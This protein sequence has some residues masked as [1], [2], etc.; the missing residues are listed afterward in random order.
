M[1]VHHHSHTARKKWTHYF[2]E[3]LMLF[4]AVT[5][6]F[7]VENKREHY[8][9][10]QRAKELAKNLVKDLKLDTSYMHE[11][12]RTRLEK[13]RDVDSLLAALKNYPSSVNTSKV[14]Q[15]VYSLIFKIHF[16][17]AEGTVNQLKNSG[18]LRYFSKTAV[19]EKLMEYDRIVGNLEEFEITYSNNLDR[20]VYLVF[21]HLDA[22]IA[23]CCWADFLN[24]K[25]IPS[26]APL[27]DMYKANLNYFKNV[28]VS[29]KHLNIVSV[30][31]YIEPSE[32]KAIELMNVIQ[33]EFQLK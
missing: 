33:K 28:A 12:R 17:R 32:K 18:Y 3:F 9:E 25:P 6:G 22:D 5:L 13:I 20:F 10:Q 24:K 15:D 26:N 8:I 23:N 21:E 4:L 29:L 7:L 16:K 27:Y 2:W 31:N 19:P 30:N 14:Y 1:D 11:V